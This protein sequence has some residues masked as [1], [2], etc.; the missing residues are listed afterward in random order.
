MDERQE[1]RSLKKALNALCYMNQE[2]EATVASLAV[3]IG[4]PRTTATRVLET[5]AA[6]GYIEKAPKSRYYRLTSQ[7]LR[8]SSG[9]QEESLLLE[10]AAPRLAKLGREIGWG[11]SL[12][13]PR[14]SEMIVRVT[15]NLDSPILLDRYAAGYRVPILY[16][17]TGLCFLALCS[18]AERAAVLELARQTN[19]P[20]EQ[21]VHDAVRLEASLAHIREHGFCVIEHPEY[22]EANVGVPLTIYGR[23]VG[24]IVMRYIKSAMKP[25][26]LL[27][28]YIPL[29]KKLSSD[30]QFECEERLARPSG[31][32]TQASAVAGAS[33][34]DRAWRDF[35]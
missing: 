34:E 11:I 21:L 6:E 8:L 26:Q 2:G 14:A 31:S 25:E 9:F 3:A 18:P 35:H 19:D 27:K 20:R 13:T 10:A 7:V 23:A 22:R 1:L 16:T 24:G 12:S 29:I 33:L 5:L 4:V 28:Y 32:K 17:T 15:T 30:I